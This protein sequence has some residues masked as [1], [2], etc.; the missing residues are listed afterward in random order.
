MYTASWSWPPKRLFRLA[1]ISSAEARMLAGL[2]RTVCKCWREADNSLW[3][4]PDPRRQYTLSKVMC[5]VALDR[6]LRLDGQG[7]ISLGRDCELFRRERA[8]IGELVEGAGF[9]A[10]VGSYVSELGG[11]QVDASLLLIGCLDYRHAADLRMVGTYDRIVQRLGRNGLLYRY[12]HGYDG[13]G[14][15][16]GAFGICS[17]WAVDILARRGDVDAAERLFDRLLGFANDLGLYAEEIDPETGTALGNFPQAFTHVG[18]I[19]A[20]LAIEHTREAAR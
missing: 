3:E 2:G 19:N 18:I 17:F 6:L 11:T 15:R 20:A 10:A 5:W 7:M 4:I 14:S 13:F 12:E 9:N 16:E 1:A 8:A